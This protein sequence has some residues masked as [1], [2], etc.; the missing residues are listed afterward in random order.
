MLFQGGSGFP[1][2]D[3][4]FILLRPLSTVFVFS[5]IFEYVLFGLLFKYIYFLKTYQW[6][7]VD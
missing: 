6:D 4:A 1:E 7:S 5:Y 3:E 2:T